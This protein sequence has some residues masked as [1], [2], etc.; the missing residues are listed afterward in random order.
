MLVTTSEE[1]RKLLRKELK[2]KGWTQQEWADKSRCN[3]SDIKAILGTDSSR[4]LQQVVLGGACEA[5][6]VNWR[7]VV[8]CCDVQLTEVR[9]KYGEYLKLHHG[10][11][12]CLD[13]SYPIGLDDVFIEVNVLEKLTRSLRLGQQELI[14]QANQEDFE[15]WGFGGIQEKGVSGLEALKKFP[16]LVVLGKPGSGKTTFLRRVAILNLHKQFL[17]DYVSVFVRL[18][19]F[20]AESDEPSLLDYIIRHWKSKGI[21]PE[22]TQQLLRKGQVL[23]LLDGLDE[24][25]EADSQRVVRAIEQFTGKFLSNYFALTC[26]IAA[27]EYTFPSFTEVEV[28]DFKF[29]QIQDFADKWFNSRDTRK[30]A[31]EFMKHLQANPRIQQLATSPLLLTLLC[32]VFEDSGQFMESRA[33]L[34]KQ[35]IELLLFKW[36]SKQHNFQRERVYNA[37][38]PRRIQDLL[39]EIAKAPFE[40]EEY[41]FRQRDLELWIG[42]FIRNLPEAQTD[43]E[44]LKVESSQVLK[45]IAEHGLLIERAQSYWSFSHLTF[46][47][48][49]L[50]QAIVTNCNPTSLED[51]VLNQLANHVTK[52]QWREVLLLVVELLPDATCLL[53]IIKQKVDSLVENEEILQE[54]LNSLYQKSCSVNTKYKPAGVRAFYL[55]GIVDNYGGRICTIDKSLDY[56]LSIDTELSSILG[57][58][59]SEPNLEQ[60]IKGVDTCL[61]RIIEP[62][63]E[64]DYPRIIDDIDRKQD[65][66]D[67]WQSA[68]PRKDIKSLSSAIEKADDDLQGNQDLKQAL[69]QLQY[70]LPEK[71]NETLEAWLKSQ[72][73]KDWSEQL[74]QIMIKYRG[75]GYDWQGLFTREQRE[76]FKSYYNA[77]ELLVKCLFK[78]NCFVSRKVRQEIEDTLLLPIAEI[79]SRHSRT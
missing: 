4:N 49:F 39:G 8:D 37:L 52:R 5:L 30:S 66:F 69:E 31:A 77:N 64:E 57:T 47:E 41:F 6:G 15:R 78:T 76:L 1:G 61:E 11:I 50:A 44:A 28:A 45:S 55:E 79:N 20:A 36:D 21:D 2:S 74:R 63:F 12:K 24:V 48:Y 75:F 62:L 25:K 72:K 10:T 13:M 59:L 46:H 3:L 9:E 40:K 38:N 53:Q 26:R 65:R 7:D 17:P 33:D 35:G 16:R 42:N 27:R 67:L 71:L 54:M 56:D 43:L 32:L 60:Y 68:A 19:D 70:R 58:S 51:P 73:S 34:Y 14:Q 29:P 22:T 23:V 18:S